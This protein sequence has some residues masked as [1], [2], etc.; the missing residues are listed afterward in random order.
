MTGVVIIVGV[1]FLAG[2]C[3]GLA[4]AVRTIENLESRVKKIDMAAGY[5]GRD[6]EEVQ[7]LS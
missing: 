4:L 1:A 7:N 6:D 5:M 3:V 2:L